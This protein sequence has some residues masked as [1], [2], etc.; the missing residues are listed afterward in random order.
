LR[1][2]PYRV[3]VWGPGGVGRACLRE[4][5]RL[6]EFVIVGVLAFSPEKNGKDVGELIDHDP[7]GVR[8]TT[9]KEAI[10]ALDT[11]AVLYCG[12]LALRCAE[13]RE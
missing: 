6:P 5:L 11:D 12:M 3:V 4:L 9:D 8:V 10:F 13:Q 1:K 7:I 2:H